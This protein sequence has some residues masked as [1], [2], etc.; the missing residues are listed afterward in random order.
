MKV[1]QHE[2][3]AC[4]YEKMLCLAAIINSVSM[5]VVHLLAEDCIMTTRVIITHYKIVSR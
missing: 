5:I 3:I 2:Y 1:L 4:V